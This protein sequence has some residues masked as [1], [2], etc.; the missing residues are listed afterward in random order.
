MTAA[1]SRKREFNILISAGIAVQ[2][3]ARIHGSLQG[4]PFEALRPTLRQSIQRLLLA[5]R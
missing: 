1:I 4:N 3:R 5:L 2:M